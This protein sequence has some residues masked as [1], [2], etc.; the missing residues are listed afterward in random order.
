MVLTRACATSMSLAS[1][2]TAP[3]RRRMQF[4]SRAVTSR[5]FIPAERTLASESRNP[6]TTGYWMDQLGECAARDG[7]NKGSRHECKVE[8][9][10]AFGIVKGQERSSEFC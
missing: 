6:V 2:Q 1:G 3:F 8:V 5:P 9:E 7:C 4:T 10:F